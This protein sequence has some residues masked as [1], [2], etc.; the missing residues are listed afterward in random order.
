MDA[1][2]WMDGFSLGS[3]SPTNIPIVE[4]FNNFPMFSK[5]EVHP[6]G[7]PQNKKTRVMHL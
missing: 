3:Y 5:I 1:P 4:G 7:W 2:P 6:I